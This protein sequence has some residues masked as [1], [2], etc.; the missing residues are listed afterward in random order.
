M[1]ERFEKTVLITGANTGIGA[2]TATE[3]AR[4]G[5]RVYFACRNEAK[6]RPVMNEIAK[7]TGND[8]LHFLELKLDDLESVKKCAA[9]FKA[10]QEPLHVLLL[11]AGLARVKGVTKQGFEMTF[12]VNHLGH[13][14][15]TVELEEVLKTSA[16]ARVVT[17]ASRA[18]ERTSTPLA[19]NHVKSSL[20][21]V[22]WKEYQASKLANV[23]FTKELARRWAGS[24]VTSYALHPGVI[25]SD[26]WRTTA[27]PLRTVA[28]WFMRTPEQGSTASLRCAVDPT[29]EGVSGKYYGE[30]GEERKASPLAEDEKAARELWDKS[31]EWV[32]PFRN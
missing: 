20:T 25:A 29:L 2:A 32:S 7:Q 6:T 23:L 18:H 13:F 9:E 15:L 5:A 8:D 11:N 4:R 1:T 22:G 16:P 19:L 14:L 17:V 24:G 12:G 31:L 30:H 3:L 21:G 28:M 27:W 10:K 26:I